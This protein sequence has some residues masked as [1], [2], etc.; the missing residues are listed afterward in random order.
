VATGCCDVSA[1]E[2]QKLAGVRPKRLC[3]SKSII[4]ASP[5]SNKTI[6]QGDPMLIASELKN[7]ERAKRDFHAFV[8]EHRTSQGCHLDA[9]AAALPL[10]EATRVA[11]SEVMNAFF[12]L[13]PEHEIFRRD[14]AQVCRDEVVFSF[15]KERWAVT[16]AKLCT[17]RI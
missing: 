2:Q 10:V 13:H 6:H 17:T 7:L 9:A 5:A 11:R 8:A 1:E 15:S 14:L 16:S 12:E 4:Y 3:A